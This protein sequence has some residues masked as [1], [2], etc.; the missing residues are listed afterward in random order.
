MPSTAIGTLVKDVFIV[1]GV[2]K[3]G[4]GRFKRRKTPKI[5]PIG[6]L[7]PLSTNR[8]EIR[9]PPAASQPQSRHLLKLPLELRECIY[10]HAL[11]G[12]LITIQ[13]IESP[14]KEFSVIRSRFYLPPDG[15][16]LAHSPTKDL[17]AERGIPTPLLLS[18][19]QIYSE[20]LPILHGH[21]TF[22]FWT[23]HLEPVIRCGL[24]YHTLLFIRSVYIFHPGSIFQ[25][26]PWTGVFTI[27]HHMSGLESVAFKF[28]ASVEQFTV[29]P[30]RDPFSAVLDSGWG[31]CVLGLR[32]LRRFEL[33][34]T[35]SP[36]VASPEYL[37]YKREFV[38]RLQQLMTAGRD[39]RRRLLQIALAP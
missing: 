37:M 10:E 30:E 13:I 5:P 28:A 7:T 16:G 17:P 9:H 38:E 1:C 29:E 6:N 23:N 18:C 2:G 27:L 34:F 3:C 36:R 19:R 14:R 15:D 25:Y 4:T 35:P 33:W 8:I 39:E 20:A 26:G 22:H 31:R 32:N 12:R 11:G 21:N 24:G